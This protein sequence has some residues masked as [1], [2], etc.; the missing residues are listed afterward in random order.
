[1]IASLS[2]QGIALFFLLKGSQHFVSGL[3]TVATGG[4]NNKVVPALENGMDYNQLGSSDLN[5]SRVCM[6]TM[7]FGEVSID[8]LEKKRW[9]LLIALLQYILYCTQT[10]RE[11]LNSDV[12]LLY[13]TSSDVFLC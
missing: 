3:S 5:V 12:N 7:T 10:N 1:M 8:M 11:I 13:D 6:G 4:V 9:S 2:K